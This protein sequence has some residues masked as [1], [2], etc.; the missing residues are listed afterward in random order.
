[1]KVDVHHIALNVTDIER[2]RRFYEAVF[3]WKASRVSEEAGQRF[4]FL[5]EADR[6]VLTLWE[7]SEGAFPEDRPGLHHLAFRAESPEEL[8]RYEAR[9][10]NLGVPLIYDGVVPHAEG[11][12]SGGLFF[13]D[14]DG[15]RLEIAADA[16]G[17]GRAAPSG[18]LP[19][20][21]FF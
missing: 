13:L 6:L 7:Q 20:C 4:V 12:R 9:L 10:E 1:M 21:G 5:S 2:S 14:P 19:S 17:E 18:S 11:A 16:A 3:G 8:K 15:L